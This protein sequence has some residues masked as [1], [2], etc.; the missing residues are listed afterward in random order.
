MYYLFNL[1]MCL[2]LDLLQLLFKYKLQ[3]VGRIVCYQTK[4]GDCD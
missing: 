4:N 1:H 2:L 3:Y